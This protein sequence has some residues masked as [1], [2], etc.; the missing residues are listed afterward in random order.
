[1]IELWE[2]RGLRWKNNCVAVEVISRLVP[3]SVP[4]AVTY[5]ITQTLFT[6]L[7]PFA[8]PSSTTTAHP[9]VADEL[10]APVSPLL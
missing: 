8:F 7:I 3:L 1:M 10:W 6:L 9:P 2:F 4:Q 5:I